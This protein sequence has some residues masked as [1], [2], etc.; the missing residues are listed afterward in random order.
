VRTAWDAWATGWLP[1]AC[2]TPASTRPTLS[3]CPAGLRWQDRA[4]I[5]YRIKSV[6]RGAVT[7][8]VTRLIFGCP[9]WNGDLWQGYRRK[10][11][12]RIDWRVQLNVRNALGSSSYIPVVANPDGRIA[13]VRNPP[14]RE[15]YLK[16]TFSF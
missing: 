14:P 11:F 10:L 15:Y 13:V 16:N 4:A 3:A 2:S 5:G 7:P 6:V 8:H 9:E 12:E 1:K